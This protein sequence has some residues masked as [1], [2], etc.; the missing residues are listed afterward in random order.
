MPTPVATITNLTATG[1]VITG[2]GA[3]TILYKGLPA[4]CMGDLVAGPMCVTGAITMT[5]AITNLYMG[6]PVSNLGSMV[7]GV[8]P[9]GIPMSTALA[10]CTNINIIV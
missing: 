2:P 7:V 6:R 10:V 5:T 8:S 9:I 1:D 3:P 4:A